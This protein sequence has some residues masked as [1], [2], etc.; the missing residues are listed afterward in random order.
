[1]KKILT[2]LFAVF[3]FVALSLTSC[4]DDNEPGK[5]SLGK[6]QSEKVTVAANE[7]Y[8]EI[9]FNAAAPWSAYVESASQADG[10]DW[11]SLSQSNGDAGEIHLTF[12]L[13]INNTGQTRKAI[14]VIICEDT[15]I[16]IEISQS[17]DDEPDIPSGGLSI[18][19]VN[20]VKKNYIYMEDG[21]RYEDYEEAYLFHYTDVN[22]E[23]INHSWRDDIDNGPGISGDDYVMNDED[24]MFSRS[25]NNIRVDV[26]NS[27]R[28]YPSRKLE[29]ERSEHFAE[30]NESLMVKSGW[31]KWDEDNLQTDFDIVY[32]QN[33]D[34]S[35]SRNNDGDGQN[36]W[37][38][39]HLHGKMAT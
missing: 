20:I 19:E 8:G 26:V 11:I 22:I 1:M 2:L 38:P 25:S 9:S 39:I 5:V 34:I 17:P 37:T 28:Y 21:N 10:L 13:E 24:W 35:S 12:T 23:Q 32:G 16:R 30:L 4:S 15:T 33:L 3:S 7:T 6:G 29:F 36:V 18:G 27:M 14:V 31:Y